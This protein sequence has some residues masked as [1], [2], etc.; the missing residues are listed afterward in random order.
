MIQLA[1]GSG[2]TA[3]LPWLSYVV[4]QP[5]QATANR[6]RV[7]RVLLVWAVKEHEHISW[8]ESALMDALRLEQTAVTFQIQIYVTGNSET[9]A[10]LAPET[11]VDAIEVIEFPEKFVQPKPRY[12]NSKLKRAG[13]IQVIRRNHIRQTNNKQTHRR[14]GWNRQIISVWLWP[15]KPSDS[16][17]NACAAAQKKVLSGKVQEVTI[18]LEALGW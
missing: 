8:A 1:G 6:L 3:C 5:R 9:K 11:I 15:E 17:A 12:F 7:K 14:R 10:L 4:G 18:H 13:T 2:I 16:L